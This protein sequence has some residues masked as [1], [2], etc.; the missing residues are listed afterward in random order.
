[1]VRRSRTTPVPTGAAGSGRWTP[2]GAT[3][4]SWPGCVAADPEPCAQGD[5]WGVSWSPDGKKIAF[6]RDYNSIG[7]KDRP[8]FVMDADGSHQQR[9]TD[10][11]ENHAVPAWQPKGVGH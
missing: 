3:T 7:I 1:M 4:S 10:G 9:L 11:T 6:L 2:T 8:V 5:D